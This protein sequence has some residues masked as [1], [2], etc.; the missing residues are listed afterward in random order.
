MG[1]RGRGSVNAECGM[2]DAEYCV[3]ILPTGHRLPTPDP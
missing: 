3:C 2:R 1:V